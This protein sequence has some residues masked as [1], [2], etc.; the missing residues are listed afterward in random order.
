[1]GFWHELRPSF[2]FDLNSK[3]KN[4][5][6]KKRLPSL[7]QGKKNVVPRSCKSH[8]RGINIIRFFMIKSSQLKK[9]ILASFT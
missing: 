7:K 9:K 6:K 1:M 3:N 5:L 8:R 2:S 4:N